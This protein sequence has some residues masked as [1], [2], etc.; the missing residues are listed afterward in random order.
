MLGLILAASIVDAASANAEGGAGIFGPLNAA[1]T[2]SSSKAS[3]QGGV[4]DSNS[5]RSS[6]TS[7]GLVVDD[8]WTLLITRLG[9]LCLHYT[10][11]M[12]AFT[13][14]E[15]GGSHSGTEATKGDAMTIVDADEGHDNMEAEVR[16]AAESAVQVLGLLSS[17]EQWRRQ[18]PPGA[19][20]SDE[21][22]L[23]CRRLLASLALG[24]LRLRPPMAGGDVSGSGVGIASAT[25]QARRPL[26]LQGKA[27]SARDGVR[28]VVRASKDEVTGDRMRTPRLF[29]VLRVLWDAA[30]TAGGAGSGSGGRVSEAARLL[31]AASLEA[32][33]MG[34][35]M[36][37]D[38]MRQPAKIALMSGG[39]RQQDGG[40]SAQSER[41]D[42]QGDLVGEERR[43]VLTTFA[44]AVLPAPRL[45]E[46][47]LRAFLVDPML[48]GDAAAWWELVSVAGA[49]VATGEG[50]AG[51][52]SGVGRG[53]AAR[54]DVAWTFANILKVR[55]R[56]AHDVKNGY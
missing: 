19:G 21:A 44:S 27:K 17:P 56:R 38:G 2:A 53:M 26:V 33:G 46:H 30:A 25:A 3:G 55:G 35:S 6:D 18:C 50:G 5:T 32:L 20:T 39:T 41:R 23:L 13:G 37:N 28:L 48:A 36:P 31:C 54:R 22:H 16:G 40:L 1:A 15:V 10:A 14:K 47:P 52:I 42:K 51:S 4:S 29:G 49:D 43:E 34:G 9:T 45:L 24:K 8:Q 12:V 11:E 7:P